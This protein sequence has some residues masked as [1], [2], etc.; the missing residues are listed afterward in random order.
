ML[1]DKIQFIV[2]QAIELACDFLLRLDYR[3]SA[4]N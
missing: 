1:H 2:K 3:S 4:E